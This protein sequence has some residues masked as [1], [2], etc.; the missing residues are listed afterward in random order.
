MSWNGNI[1]PRNE[2]ST[3]QEKTL[4][5]SSFAQTKATDKKVEVPARIKCNW[6]GD[7]HYVVDCGKQD[8]IARK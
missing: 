4:D 1:K 7:I 2:D 5:E 6:C 3:E 8:D